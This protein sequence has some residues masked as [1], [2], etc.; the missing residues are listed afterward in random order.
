MKKQTPRIYNI[1]DPDAIEFSRTTVGNLT[2]YLADFTAVDATL[3][4]KFVDKLTALIDKAEKTLSDEVITDRQVQLTNALNKKMDECK[5][6]YRLISYF[7]KNAFEENPAIRNEFGENDYSSIKYSHQKMIIF[8]QTLITITK[9]YKTELIKAGASQEQL[10]KTTTLH[11]EL[12]KANHNQELFMANRPVL[13]SER[14]DNLNQ[15]WKLISRVSDLS[16]IIYAD[17]FAKLKLFLLPQRS[18]SQKDSSIIIEAQ[19]TQIAIEN[20]VHDNAY[21]KIE[22]TGEVDLQIYVSNKLLEEPHE[23]AF[24]L[25][26][27]QNEILKSNDI[28]NDTFGMLIIVNNTDE[29]GKFKTILVE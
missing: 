2:N 22:N 21:I 25:K 29:E 9:K 11:N 16:K 23:N 15:I 18:A 12:S 5:A 24:T 19:S 4:Q 20:G 10:D 27:Q 1:S 26:P 7:A 3:N 14:I 17:D 28:S 13:T 8:M 6:H